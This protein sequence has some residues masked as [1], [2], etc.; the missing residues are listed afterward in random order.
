M[1][2]KQGAK[3]LAD[4]MKDAGPKTETRKYF[5]CF[6]IEF[7]SDFTPDLSNDNEE[8]N[9][10]LLFEDY[11]VKQGEK[12]SHKKDDKEKAKKEKIAEITSNPVTGIMM[13]VLGGQSY[14]VGLNQPPAKKK[15]EKEEV[16]YAVDRDLEVLAILVRG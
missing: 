16:L 13:G 5:R 11:I 7:G 6:N 3:K 2:E 14:N 8:W 10:K 15:K 12:K 4:A 1:I 9:E